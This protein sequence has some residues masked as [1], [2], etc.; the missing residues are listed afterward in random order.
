MIDVYSL[1]LPSSLSL[2]LSLLLSLC[3]RRLRHHFFLCRFWM[4]VVCDPCHRYPPMSS[5][6]Q[7]PPPPLLSPPPLL[8]S[9]LPAAIAAN[10][11]AAIATMDSFCGTVLI[12]IPR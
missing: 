2:R 7:L 3:R 8:P 4:V 10:A 5:L 6:L 1:S 11:I 12:L 9:L